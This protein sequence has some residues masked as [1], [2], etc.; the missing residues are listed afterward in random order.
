MVDIASTPGSLGE[1]VR[2][3]TPRYVLGVDLD[4]LF[5]LEDK[6]KVRLERIIRVSPRSIHMF[7]KSLLADLPRKGW[8]T[9][10]VEYV[11][12]TRRIRKNSRLAGLVKA[13]GH[14]RMPHGRDRFFV[15]RDIEYLTSTAWRS[16]RRLERCSKFA[17]MTPD[18][19]IMG[20][21]D[22]LLATFPENGY[23]TRSTT[24]Q[25]LQYHRTKL[26]P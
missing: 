2:R 5:S 8:H 19:I 23:H 7:A 22:R 13:L 26:K 15:R 1:A 3:T 12:G 10:V 9:G 18:P 4:Y 14:S 21:C 16:R 24:V 6:V 20:L 17:K 25:Q 11:D